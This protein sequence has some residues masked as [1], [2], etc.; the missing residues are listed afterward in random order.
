MKKSNQVETLDDILRNSIE[1]KVKEWE[2]QGLS[3]QEVSE[4]LYS[5]DVKT[6]SEQLLTQA[7]DDEFGFF[8]EHMNEI[9]ASEQKEEAEFCEKQTQKWGQCLKA[10]RTMYVIAVEAAETY[11]QAI[12]Q[13]DDPKLAQRNYT[14]LALQH[15][16]GRV[17]QEFLEIYYLLRFGFADGAYARWRSMYELCCCGQFIINYGEQIAKQY[18]EQAKTEL[19]N[20]QWTDGAINKEGKELRIVNF[21]KLQDSIEVNE[22]WKQQYRVACLVNHGSPQGTFGRL[23][24]YGNM[25]VIPV[26]HSDFG[27]VVPAVNAAACLAWTSRL[28]LCIFP[29]ADSIMHA[30]LLEKWYEM[31]NDLYK[32]TEKEL[33]PNVDVKYAGKTE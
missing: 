4:K 12:P 26:G 27:L 29:T 8:K 19:R 24:N 17:C 3:P 2:K 22:K 11:S 15:I 9:D 28:F 32:A 5:I 25:D 16:Q 13:K 7:T 10:S 21:D 6:A 18:Y 23:A 31:I 30:S 33:F 20:Y 1:K 14:F